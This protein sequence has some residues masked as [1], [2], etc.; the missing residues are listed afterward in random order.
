MVKECLHVDETLELQTAK[1][2]PRFTKVPGLLM[3]TI[4]CEKSNDNFLA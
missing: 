3:V 4:G 2:R 1:G